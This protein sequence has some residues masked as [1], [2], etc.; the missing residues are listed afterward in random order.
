MIYIEVVLLILHHSIEVVVVSHR[1][2]HIVR[3]GLAQIGLRIEGQEYLL[4]LIPVERC[5]IVCEWDAITM[6]HRIVFRIEQFPATGQNLIKSRTNGWCLQT[7]GITRQ[8][9]RRCRQRA[10]LRCTTLQ[11]QVDVHH[12]QLVYQADTL[13]LVIW[14]I[15]GILINDRNDLL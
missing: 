12:M 11:L 14:L 4:I 6:Q 15:I 3:V 10:N 2:W 5:T 9:S 8:Y 1:Q 7:D 13:T